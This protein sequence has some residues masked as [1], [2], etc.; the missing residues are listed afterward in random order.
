MTNHIKVVWNEQGDKAQMR[1]QI[2]TLCYY[3]EQACGE[4]ERHIRNGMNQREARDK[5]EREINSNEE[6]FRDFARH[7]ETPRKK[8]DAIRLFY[9]GELSDEEALE[10]AKRDGRFRGRKK[11]SVRAYLKTF[12]KGMQMV[13]RHIERPPKDREEAP[14][15]W[16][17][18]DRAFSRI[19]DCVFHRERHPRIRRSA[20]RREP[21]HVFRRSSRPAAR[22]VASSGGDDSGG[23][24]PPQSDPDLPSRPLIGGYPLV[25]PSQPDGFSP[26]SWRFRRPVLMSHAFARIGSDRA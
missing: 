3:P 4:F 26:S 7:S 9:E 19:M 20:Y 16:E 8:V 25:F 21:G 17:K 23:S 6:N 5:N 13:E 24:E 2:R 22:A 11:S 18:Y 12:S 15:E 14:E 10:E 1:R